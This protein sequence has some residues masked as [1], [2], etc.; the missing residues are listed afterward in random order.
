[1]NESVDAVEKHIASTGEKDAQELITMSYKGLKIKRDVHASI[2]LTEAETLASKNGVVAVTLLL[3][4]RLE[5]LV[6]ENAALAKT[7][8]VTEEEIDKKR[9]CVEKEEELFLAVL[10]SHAV[11]SSERY[12]SRKGIGHITSWNIRELHFMRTIERVQEHLASRQNLIISIAKDYHRLSGL[13]IPEK[14]TQRLNRIVILAHNTH[15]GDARA[16]SAGKE[17]GDL[18]LGQLVRER[19]GVD[20]SFLLGLTTTSGRII[21]AN[22]WGGQSFIRKLSPPLENSYDSIFHHDYRHEFFINFRELKN[23]IDEKGRI[24]AALEKLNGPY[25]LRAIGVI[26]RQD[27]EVSSHYILTNIIDQFDGIMI[28]KSSNEITPLE[29][30]VVSSKEEIK[31][32]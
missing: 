29:S 20:K 12:F 28:V 17:R 22:E 26:Y 18:S 23:Q 3:E 14:D 2:E 4:A 15:V 5:I 19:L 10:N 32:S 7:I 11:K 8:S 9:K 13:S 1:M 21:A 30:V 27:N 25:E 31:P 24:K 16:N 6:S